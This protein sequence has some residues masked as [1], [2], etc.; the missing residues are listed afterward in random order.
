MLK[1]FTLIAF[2]VLFCIVSN[3]FAQ[4]GSW[5]EL[6]GP[7]G[8]SVNGLTANSQG[9]LYASRNEAIYKSTDNG[10]TWE[11][12]TNAS[13]LNLSL[14]NFNTVKINSEGILYA[15]VSYLGVWWSSDDGESW[16]YN[17]ITHNPHS[18]LGASIYYITF[19]SNNDIFVSHFRST[20]H[21]ANWYEMSIYGYG[22]VF[23]S[24]NKIFA[25]TQDGVY[26][27]TDN[28]TTW[29]PSNSG[30]ENIS[31]HPI[32]QTSNGYI[33]AGS[34]QVGIY[35]SSD[36]GASWIQSNSGLNDLQISSLTV[37]NNDNILAG[38]V[39]GEIYISTDFGSNWNLK[40]NSSVNSQINEI[41]TLP[42]STPA[43]IYTATNGDGIFKSTDLGNSWNV[44]NTGLPLTYPKEMFTKSNDKIFMLSGNRIIYSSD[45][46]NSWER[47]DT[48]FSNSNIISLAENNNNE[49]F[50]GLYQGGLYRSTDEGINWNQVDLG[51]DYITP[52]LFICDD[53]GGIVFLSSDN[54]IYR[55]S[56]NGSTWNIVFD[57]IGQ[58]IL[59]DEINVTDDGSI[60]ICG[61]TFFVEAYVMYSHDGGNTWNQYIFPN[62]SEAVSLYT[63]QN[64]VYAVLDDNTISKT[65]DGGVAWN[66]IPS[67]PWSSQPASMTFLPNGASL[68]GT[69]NEGVFYSAANDDNW[70]TFNTG[71]PNISGMYG[72]IEVITSNENMQLF[73]GTAIN[74]T[75]INN[76]FTPV[77]L[78][79]FNA[80]VNNDE[81]KLNW[82]TSTETNNNGFEIERLNLKSEIPSHEWKRIGFV[83]G[84]GTTT[85]R[86]SYSFIDNDVSSGKY[87]YRLKQLD[88]DGTFSYSKEIEVIFNNPAKYNLSQN[89]P[90]PFN[91]S[92]TIKYELPNNG[93]VSL[94]VYNILGR[95]VASLINKNQNAGAYTINFNAS[96][97]ASGIYYYRIHAGNY[98]QTKKM[99]LLK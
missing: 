64:I 58:G 42:G 82:I 99:I 28:G 84:H 73:L 18:G 78:T 59:I 46:G 50:C 12:I 17:Q 7:Y 43:T 27:S 75:F 19:N 15:G 91:P 22:F 38:T 45:Q 3:I 67:N 6:N 76:S 66:S 39:S 40:E 79:S 5:S 74:G 98:T 87:N 23:T 20:D 25:T 49:L 33:F 24:S 34:D 51:N 53:S 52:K 63:K 16:D 60:Y 94:K 68:V 80:T 37:D 77:E 44:K 36:E 89:Y 54:K 4:E 29:L 26:K 81:V 41:L 2:L 92:T 47:R 57:F 62:E 72:S 96:N 69:Q 65:T 21:G 11:N 55:S 93:F 71:I 90:N 14:S 56:D 83:Q 35:L 86:Q 9:D 1:P 13:V 48:Q 95:E 70:T 31:M 32:V 10:N 30:I 85:E 61:L 88:Y 8:G 97:L